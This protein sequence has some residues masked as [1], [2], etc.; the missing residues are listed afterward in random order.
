MTA[1]NER[2]PCIP[3]LLTVNVPPLSSGG[4]TSPLRTRSARRRASAAISAS[5]LRSA[6]KIVGTTSVPSAATAMPTLTRE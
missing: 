2:T 1:S 4:V 5:G 3:R 6:S